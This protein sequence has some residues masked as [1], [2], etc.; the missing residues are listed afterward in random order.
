MVAEPLDSIVCFCHQKQQTWKDIWLIA[1]HFYSHGFSFCRFIT[2]FVCMEFRRTDRVNWG[3]I[4]NGNTLFLHTSLPGFGMKAWFEEMFHQWL[5]TE[6]SSS[7]ILEQCP[8]TTTQNIQPSWLL[9]VS[10]PTFLPLL[11]NKATCPSSW[12]PLFLTHSN[13]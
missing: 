9:L 4:M 11:E 8:L 2:I 13:I 7:D 6:P 5:L 1:F 12:N 10:F 3:A